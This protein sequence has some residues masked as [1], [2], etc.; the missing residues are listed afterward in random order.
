MLLLGWYCLS[1]VEQSASFATVWCL[2]LTV[3]VATVHAS[4]ANTVSTHVVQEGSM[5]ISAVNFV[6]LISYT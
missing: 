4:V 1:Y 5:E 2:S 6:S 3:R